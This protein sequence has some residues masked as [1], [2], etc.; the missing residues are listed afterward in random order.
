[1]AKIFNID[2]RKGNYI[3][4]VSGTAVINTNG[5][6]KRTEKGFAW[7]G[8]GTTAKLEL[9]SLGNIKA[10]A[11]YIKLNTLSEEI[12]EG[13]PNAHLIYTTAGTLIYPDFDN[14]FVDNIDTDT[15]DTGWHWVL[16]TSTT[17]VNCT[18][19][20]L[21]LNNAA[22]GNLWCS[23]IVAYDTELTTEERT[24]AYNKFLHSYPQLKETYPRLNINEFKPTDL[25]NKVNINPGTN[26]LTVGEAGVYE[27]NV[28]SNWTDIGSNLLTQDGN[29]VKYEYVDSGDV[30][31]LTTGNG[32]VSSNLISGQTYTIK[33]RTKVNSGSSVN[34]SMYDDGGGETLD[35]ITNTNYQIFEYTRTLQGANANIFPDSMTGG[36]I[37]WIELLSI[38]QPTGLEVAYN[39]IPSAGGRLVDISGENTSGV[40]DGATETLYGLSFD[41]IDDSVAL[42]I[43]LVH[44]ATIKTIC[45]RIKLASTTEMILDGDNT[46]NLVIDTTAGTLAYAAYDTA[47]IDGVE[48]DTVVANQ[49]HSIVITSSTAVDNNTPTLGRTTAAPFT[50]GKFEIADLQYWSTEFT[51]SQAQ[52]YHD[53]FVVPVIDIRFNNDA[54]GSIKPYGWNGGTA[55]VEVGEL[56]TQVSGIP[57]LDIGTKY[58]E[59]TGDGTYS[60]F[61]GDVDLRGWTIIYYYNGATWT[62]VEDA[63]IVLVA[64]YAWLSLSGG[65]L[66]FTLITGDR[67][68]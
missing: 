40:I 2:F 38:S 35:T 10:L 49:W 23:K 14:A 22:Y 64:D 45:M 20:V 46:G 11:F 3:D 51:L 13:D 33:I 60:I 66:T 62:K 16:I 31:V 43:S 59:W 7:Y 67:I 56:T 65:Y 5:V 9:G 32:T 44:A 29:A 12:F 41:G 39:M 52:D 63:L 25:S 28:V 27:A 21:A 47:Y 30:I 26:L 54:V 17:N 55:T 1:M 15:I 36:E 19:A 58:L 6:L 24:K 42:N 57:E 53:S 48:S 37:I 68:R 34:L 4:S 18:D 61:V 50:Y 8:N